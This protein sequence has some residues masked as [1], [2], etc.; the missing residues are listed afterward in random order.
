MRGH[1][2]IDLRDR[3]AAQEKLRQEIQGRLP[4]GPFDLYASL[5]FAELAPSAEDI[6]VVRVSKAAMLRDAR[7]AVAGSR[8]LRLLGFQNNIRSIYDGGVAMIRGGAKP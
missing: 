1:T 6:D 7:Y 8:T 2:A 5:A 4:E 3:H